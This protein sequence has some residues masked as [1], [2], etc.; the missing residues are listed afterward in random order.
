MISFYVLSMVELG[1]VA[2]KA[3][4]YPSLTKFCLCNSLTLDE[5]YLN[6]LVKV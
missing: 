2:A 1:A 3:M 4:M 6:E 5:Y